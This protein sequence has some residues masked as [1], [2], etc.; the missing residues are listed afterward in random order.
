MFQN[1]SV[2]KK[3]YIPIIGSIL[4]GLVVVIVS[5]YLSMQKVKEKV[6]QSQKK[7]MTHIFKLK[8]DGKKKICMTNAINLSYNKYVI[9]ALAKNDRNIAINGL[10]NLSKVF[11][12]YTF[13]RRI[14]IHIHTANVHSLVR[15]WNLKKYGDDLS[16]FRE[17]INYVAKTHK[18][19]KA[20]EIGKAGLLLRGI[21]PVMKNGEYLGSVEFIQGLNSISR[22]LQKHNIYY[23]TV[24]DKKYLNIAK[25]LVNAPTLLGNFKLATKKGAYDKEFF[26]T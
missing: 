6:F 19:L 18:P 14:K 26:M 11:K 9:D 10:K 22:T 25:G 1:F 16:G 2:S 13:F 8:L 3:I 17:T 21:A 4:V 24:M 23:I 7:D 5:S 12:E 15:L 20:F